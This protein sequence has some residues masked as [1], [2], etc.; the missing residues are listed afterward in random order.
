MNAAIIPSEAESA[1]KHVALSG[2]SSG[3]VLEVRVNDPEAKDDIESWSR[4]SG[5]MIL[6]MIAD[7]NQELRFF[8]KKK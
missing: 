7:G 3:Q 6:K 4:L 8:V 1:H 5:N 2:L